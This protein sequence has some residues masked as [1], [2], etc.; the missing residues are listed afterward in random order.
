MESKRFAPP[1]GTINPQS[2][3]VQPTFES[4]YAYEKHMA[5]APIPSPSISACDWIVGLWMA[6]IWSPV[7]AI[8]AFLWEL[9]VFAWQ[10]SADFWILPSIRWVR[11][12]YKRTA[13]YLRAIYTFGIVSELLHGYA[14]PYLTSLFGLGSIGHG[15]LSLAAFVMSI[16]MFIS[17]VMLPCDGCRCCTYIAREESSSLR[18]A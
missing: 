3:P 1:A 16:S 17:D 2:R 14:V 9:I 8:L 12:A 15:L 6:Y 13:P 4:P 5:P 7:V 18:S 10:M 11:R